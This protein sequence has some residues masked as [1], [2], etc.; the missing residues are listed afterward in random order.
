[1]AFQLYEF[2]NITQ[3]STALAQAVINSIQ[4]ELKQKD[5]INI[6][7]SGGKSPLDF[8]KILRLYFYKQPNFSR[9]L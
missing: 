2:K 9:K 3:V 8:L 5:S 4:K 7:F 6:A 1:M